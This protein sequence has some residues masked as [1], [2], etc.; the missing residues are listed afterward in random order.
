VICARLVK[1]LYI[2]ISGLDRGV[3][4]EYF[5]EKQQIS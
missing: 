3:F 1:I 4:D 5:S 2:I